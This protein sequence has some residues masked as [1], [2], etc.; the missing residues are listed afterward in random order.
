M[1]PCATGFPASPALTARV[2]LPECAHRGLG[3]ACT[4]TAHRTA[5]TPKQT[6]PLHRRTMLPAS[7]MVAES[8]PLP[9]GPW[10]G[11]GACLASCP[12]LFLNHRGHTL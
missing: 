9:G 4:R 3:R 5:A 6:P 12:G 2:T 10:M 1:V 8:W 11:Q 7:L